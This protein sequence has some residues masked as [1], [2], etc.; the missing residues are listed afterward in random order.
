MSHAWIPFWR[1]G[2]SSYGGDVDLLFIGLLAISLA[3]TLLLLGLL[4]T[5]AVRYR[6]GSNADRSDRIHKSWHWEIGWTT[7]TLFGFL[8]L[9]VWGASLYLTV[10]A[11]PQDALPIYVVGKQWMWKV[12]H[13]G[14]QREINELHVPVQQSVRLIMASQ[15]VIHSFF[16][17]A[18]RVKHDV[19]PGRYQNLWFKAE[20]TGVFHLLCAEFCGTDHSRMTGRI[21]V[22]DA[23]AYGN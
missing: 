21:V 3:V 1:S 7:V 9:F 12:Q 6:V 11:Q 23:N 2:A 19:V 17:P 14:G 16:V 20:K 10:Y 22:M 13:S 4:V 18:F 5:F 15:D 8:G